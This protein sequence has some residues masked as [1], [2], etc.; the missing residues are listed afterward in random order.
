MMKYM[1][2]TLVLESFSTHA[3]DYL[4]IFL[5]FIWIFCRFTIYSKLHIVVNMSMYASHLYATDSDSTSMNMYI[6]S[7]AG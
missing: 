5:M 6:L 1:G 3:S 4:K 7:N 2:N